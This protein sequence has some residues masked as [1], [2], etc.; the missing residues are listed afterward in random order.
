MPRTSLNFISSNRIRNTQ[1]TF[2]QKKLIIEVVA[3]NYSSLRI[4]NKCEMSKSFIRYILLISFF[5][6]YNTFTKRTSRFKNLS[7]RD[8]KH[9]L[10]IVRRT[11]KITYKNLIEKTKLDCSHNT[12]YW[13]LKE[14]SI[15]N[16]LIKKQSLLMFKHA[17]LRYE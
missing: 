17:A 11:S 12:I 13:L 10:R 6:N 2:Y 9:I 14:K 5:Y 15:I 16:W 4:R 8:K 3:A 1:Y 7:I